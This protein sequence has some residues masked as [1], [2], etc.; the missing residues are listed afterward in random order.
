[1]KRTRGKRGSPSVRIALVGLLAVSFVQSQAVFAPALA[2][3]CG[4]FRGT[5]RLCRQGIHGALVS[6]ARRQPRNRELSDRVL[7]GLST[8]LLHESSR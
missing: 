1:M 5:S 4:L 6:Q 7:A 3:A 2:H 8:Q